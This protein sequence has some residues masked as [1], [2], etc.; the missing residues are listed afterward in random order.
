MVGLPVLQ[1]NESVVDEVDVALPS[2]SFTLVVRT[3]TTE[4]R[5]N[6]TAIIDTIEKH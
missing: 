4:A 3:E 1:G 5:K 6:M 2:R